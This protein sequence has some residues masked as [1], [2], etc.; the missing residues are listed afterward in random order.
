MREKGIID[1]RH[2][3]TTGEHM[4]KI[5]RRQHLAYTAT[6]LAAAAS[7]ACSAQGSAE[8]SQP[9]PPPAPVEADASAKVVAPVE[10]P[11]NVKLQYVQMQ[12][13]AALDDRCQWLE[14]LARKA[15]EAS[16]QERLATLAYL[17]GD[18]A[19]AKTEASAIALSKANFDCNSEE[20]TQFHDAV[21]TMTWQM[22][23]TWVMRGYALAQQATG[24]LAE[25]LA[26]V[27]ASLTSTY[28]ALDKEF[29]IGSNLGLFTQ[30]VERATNA[31]PSAPQQDKEQALAA[32]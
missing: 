32:A 11:E 5:L 14:P 29:S 15:L 26:P 6:L 13:M 22:R 28:Q 9:P 27:K 17:D 21:H 18:I 7:A 24:P 4:K 3:T 23:V 30:E 10:Q 20:A 12:D 19:A 1:H 25:K 2:S 8:Q 16:I 31:N